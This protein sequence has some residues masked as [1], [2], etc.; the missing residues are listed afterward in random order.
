[1]GRAGVEGGGNTP[2]QTQNQKPHGGGEVLEITPAA[3]ARGRTDV[4]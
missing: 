4:V 1:M 2:Y 3:R